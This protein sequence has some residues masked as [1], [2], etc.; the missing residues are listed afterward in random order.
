MKKI[1]FVGVMIFAFA[2]TM[3]VAFACQC[4][5][6]QQQ[7]ACPDQSNTAIGVKNTVSSQAFSGANTIS[8]GFVG[9]A[10]IVTGTSVSK[11]IGANAVNSNVKTGWSFGPSAQTNK[12]FGVENGVLSGAQSGGNEVSGFVVGGGT[13]WT[14]K[15][16]AKTAGVN[17]VNTNV[18]L[19][20]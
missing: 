11:T 4:M 12:A 15:S 9:S 14:G 18:K 16:V 6:Y 8:G 7:C 13:V 2:L 3:N 20:H 17:L 1:L 19:S 10:A 5:P